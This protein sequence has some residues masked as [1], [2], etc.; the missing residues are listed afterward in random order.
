MIRSSSSIRSFRKLSSGSTHSKTGYISNHPSGV[1]LQWNC[2]VCY[3]LQRLIMWFS[4]LI[5]DVGSATELLD[6]HLPIPCTSPPIKEEY[7]VEYR[8][9]RSHKLFSLLFQHDD[10]VLLRRLD[11]WT[12]P[13]YY[14]RLAA[15]RKFSPETSNLRN[16]KYVDSRTCPKCTCYTSVKGKKCI[17][18][19]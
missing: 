13:A 1:F 7:A 5:E 12:I 15:F 18:R 11:E 19:F 16:P 4:L 8:S 9:S 17:M 14:L 6:E 3:R 10:V 2:F